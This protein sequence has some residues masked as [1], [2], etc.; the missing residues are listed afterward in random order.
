MPLRYSIRMDHAI[1]VRQ[2][3]D[4]PTVYLDHWAVRR[5]SDDKNLQRRFVKALHSAGGTLFLSHQNFVEFVGPDDAR[6]AEHAEQFLEKVLPNIYFAEID[7]QKAITQEEDSRHRGQRLPP[8]PDLGLL[9]ILALHPTTPGAFTIKGLITEVT[10]H[11]DRLGKTFRKTNQELANTINVQRG[12][13]DFVNKAK[14]FKANKDRARTS[15]VIAEILR[16][17]IL[18]PSV[19]ITASDAADIHHAIIS[20][21]YCDYVLLDGKWEDTIQRMKHR[22]ATLELP[23]THARCFSERRNGLESFLRVLEAQPNPC[24]QPAPASGHG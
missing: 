18:D 17:V 1:E 6:H 23:I 12:K 8:P 5:F 11:R 22:I 14:T 10:R 13:P 24:L 7:I 16:G 15:I 3:F 2:S 4:S 20:T 21:S 19:P 9:K